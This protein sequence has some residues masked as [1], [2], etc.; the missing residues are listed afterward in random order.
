MVS[1]IS[2]RTTLEVCADALLDNKRR[3]KKKKIR[4]G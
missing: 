1:E 3:R 4:G 2:T